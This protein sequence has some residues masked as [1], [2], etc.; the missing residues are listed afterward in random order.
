MSRLEIINNILEKWVA[1]YNPLQ[2]RDKY[3]RWCSMG[4]WSSFGEKTGLGNPYEVGENGLTKR[5]L[6]G[7]AGNEIPDKVPRIK[8]LDGEQKKIQEEFAKNW[9]DKKK[10]AEALKKLKDMEPFNQ[11]TVET[12]AIK[13]LDPRWGTKDRFETLTQKEVDGTASLAE[14]NELAGYRKYRQEN[15]TILHQ[16]ANA[17]AKEYMRQQVA[18]DPNVT[19]VVTSGG[20]G[21]GK[22]FGLQE[23]GKKLIKE[24]SDPKLYSKFEKATSGKKLIWDAAGDQN[25]TE[26]D[27]VS[28]LGQKN[29]VILHTVGDP[30]FNA[31]NAVYAKKG[32]AKS[33][34]SGLVKRALS[35]GRMVDGTVYAQSYEIG[36]ANAQ[37][38]YQSQKGNSNIAFFKIVNPGKGYNGEVKE[39]TRLVEFTTKHK[40]EDIKLSSSQATQLIKDGLKELP[41]VSQSVKDSI[42]KGGTFVSDMLA[43]F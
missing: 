19:V 25:G 2:P 43:K 27:W 13:Q 18:K 6:V 22:G 17:L 10:R 30:K 41:D 26:L 4:Y 34:S 1:N 38:F 11:G 7:V 28:G 14:I 24:G 20:C 42:L 37:A 31:N 32:E 35:D 15:N 16:T 8:T 12:D 39:T 9:E 23:L 21:S 36:N 33:Q 5:S 40:F 29:T 3:G